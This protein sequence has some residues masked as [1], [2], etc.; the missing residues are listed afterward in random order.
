MRVWRPILPGAGPPTAFIFS[1][2]CWPTTSIAGCCCS[3]ARKRRSWPSSSIRPWRS[4]VCAFC[5]W[6]LR[7]GGTLDVL[8]SAIAI[9]TR[10]GDYS[11]VPG[12]LNR[13]RPT[14]PA[15]DY[16]WRIYE[17]V[18]N[19]H[20]RSW[21]DFRNANSRVLSGF[22]EGDYGSLDVA[23][24]A[25]LHTRHLY[26]R[27]NRHT[28]GRHLKHVPFRCSDGCALRHQHGSGLAG[29][30]QARARSRLHLALRCDL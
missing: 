3:S 29:Q 27:G 25:V 7:S 30:F 26:Y 5:S 23:E 14:L 21:V 15:D 10:S 17:A 11:S 19:R 16:D 1:W 24:S 8:G 6:R 18:C 2:R 22:D 20:H 9:S 28:H 4:R 12:L 13:L